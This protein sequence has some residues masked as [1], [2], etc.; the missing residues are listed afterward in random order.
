MNESYDDDLEQ[1]ED[2]NDKVVQ[3]KRSQIR[4]LE[5]K[6]KA[7]DDALVR[8]A[9]L[10]RQLVFRDA[11]IPTDKRGQLFMKAYDGD[12]TLDAVKAAAIDYEVIQPD[13]A[14][15]TPETE[16]QDRLLK[17][18]GGGDTPHKPDLEQAILN[19]TTP[20]EVMRIVSQQGIKL[21]VQ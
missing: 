7:H 10:E 2:A 21:Q 6:A 8:L 9:T 12:M 16:A 19:A 13:S 1:E 20:E 17:A 18:A 15:T 11:G 4:A 5:K 3:L 14:D